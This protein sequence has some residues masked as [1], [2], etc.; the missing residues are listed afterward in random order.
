MIPVSLETCAYL[1]N[2]D[3]YV[4]VPRGHS[5]PAMCVV[6]EFE[7]LVKKVKELRFQAAGL[8][9]YFKERR[10]RT[11]AIR[12]VSHVLLSSLCFQ[13]DVFD[14]QVSLPYRGVS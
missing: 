10:K 13:S 5:Q 11:Q 12:E 1:S 8:E 9:A 6:S 3:K 4:K 14:P 2:S 7:D